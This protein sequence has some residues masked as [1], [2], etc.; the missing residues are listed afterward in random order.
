MIR[1]RKKIVGN[2]YYGA[3]RIL[4]LIA[5]FYACFNNTILMGCIY[6]HQSSIDIDKTLKK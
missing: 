6:I 4:C 3:M 2:I 1:R 5:L